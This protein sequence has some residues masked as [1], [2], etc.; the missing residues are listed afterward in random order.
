[1]NAARA[2]AAAGIVL[3][4]CAPAACAP[5]ASTTRDGGVQPMAGDTLRGTVAI[6]GSDPATFLTL[7]PADGG[8]SINLSGEA[9]EPLRSVDG[10]DVRVAGSA[11]P[12][13]FVVQRFI[14]RRVNGEDVHDGVV[15]T[16]GGG[17]A[18]RTETGLI[19]VPD[20]GPGLRR[21]LGARIWITSPLPGRAPSYGEIRS[22][23]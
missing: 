6:V 12:D 22:P 21:L 8:P 3:A 18:V 23:G 11:A 16:A 14:V 13:G 20:A 2:L 7:R 9:A 10:A 17:L 5:A 15:V 4:A 19:D 1:M